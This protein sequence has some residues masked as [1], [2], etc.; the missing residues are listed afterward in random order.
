MNENVDKHL[1]DLSRKVMSHS[2]IEQP[3]FNFTQNIM[4][5]IERVKASEVTTY[6]PLISKR[7][8]VLIAIALLSISSGLAFFGTFN[9]DNSWLR[10][11]QFD[12]FSEYSF[13]NPLA[14][15]E[16][17]QTTYYAVILFAVVMCVQIPILK[18]YFDK[19][20]QV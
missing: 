15:I 17:S 5:Q 14:N 2:T 19:R 13:P 4:V 12:R 3:S 7:I 20:L 9:D 6:V 1:D 11:L 8:W 10:Q 16:F 18:R